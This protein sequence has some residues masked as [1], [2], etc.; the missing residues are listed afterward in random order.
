MR[1]QKPRIATKIKI[2]LLLT[3]S[4]VLSSSEKESIVQSETSI[5]KIESSSAYQI[6][7][8][9]SKI[10]FK[11]KSPSGTTQ[12]FTIPD[13][14]SLNLQQVSSMTCFS[15]KNKCVFCSKSKCFLFEIQNEQLSITKE[16]LFNDDMEFYRVK[17]LSNT[18]LV[19]TV[20]KQK[21]SRW[22]TNEP[23]CHRFAS[24]AQEQQISRD[25]DV[26][27]RMAPYTKNLVH[28]ASGDK[29]MRVFDVSNMQLVRLVNMEFVG[30][31]YINELGSVDVLGDKPYENK[32]I[33]CSLNG[34]CGF[35]NYHSKQIV[36]GIRYSDQSRQ[37]VFVNVFED[38]SVFSVAFDSRK[39]AF[40]DSS[41]TIEEALYQITL[42]DESELTDVRLKRGFEGLLISTTTD[43]FV[44]KF[45]NGAPNDY[46]FEGCTG[47]SHNFDKGYCNSCADGFVERSSKCEREEIKESSGTKQVVGGLFLSLE[48]VQIEQEAGDG[49]SCYI[50]PPVEPEPEPEPTPEPT[51]EPPTVLPPPVNPIGE[52]KEDYTSLIISGVIIGCSIIIFII[53]ALY[54]K[55]KKKP[56]IVKKRKD[57]DQK[58]R[59][60][61]SSSDNTDNTDNQINIHANPNPFNYKQEPPSLKRISSPEGEFI[62]STG[63]RAFKLS[64]HGKKKKRKMNV[65]KTPNKFSKGNYRRSN[66]NLNIQPPDEEDIKQAEQSRKRKVMSFNSSSQDEDPFSDEEEEKENEIEDQVNE[67]PSLEDLASFNFD[68]D[69]I[70]SVDDKKKKIDDEEEKQENTGRSKEGDKEFDEF[71]FYDEDF[72]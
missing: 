6:A 42:S 61:D 32:V 69:S 4:S 8:S 15:G 29:F 30:E 41:I 34:F 58:V 52:V 17:A 45:T 31:D 16:F 37:Q 9:N 1:N 10:F 60:I 50:P 21:I 24:F 5:L 36:G 22:D 39:I 64:V 35:F 14:T 59:Y 55:Y 26:G 38:S 56:E 2:I 67:E 71:D 43:A 46:C 7:L 68:G 54:L 48:S 63:L 66:R 57:R 28:V 19:I 33:V 13:S 44:I 40:Y 53:I 11:K 62:E 3:V 65:K 27:I 72:L 23:S 25:G 12:S 51:K 47:C 49:G 20:D 70:Y 18:D